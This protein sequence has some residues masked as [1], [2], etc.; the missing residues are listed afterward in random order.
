MPEQPSLPLDEPPPCTD[1]YLHRA[2]LRLPADQR[3]RFTY[4]QALEHPLMGLCLRNEAE[5]MRREGALES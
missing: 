4:A 2:Y 3:R 5:A 1:T